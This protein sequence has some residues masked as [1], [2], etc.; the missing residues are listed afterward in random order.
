[1]VL[2][3]C[4]DA[5]DA[6]WCGWNG[7]R[8]NG[9]VGPCKNEGGGGGKKPD[10]LPGGEN[11]RPLLKGCGDNKDGGV[12]KVSLFF[13]FELFVVNDDNS[14]GVMDADKDF[15]GDVAWR[16]ELKDVE[17]SS[18]LIVVLEFDKSIG[19]EGGN[20]SDCDG[21]G[22][23]C[24]CC[25]FDCC[26]LLD[27]VDDGRID[28]SCIDGGGLDDVVL[29]PLVVGLTLRLEQ[30]SPVSSSTPFLTRVFSPDIELVSS[31]SLTLV[32]D[33]D[34]AP[35]PFSESFSVCNIS[36]VLDGG[37]SGT[38]NEF[39]FVV[40]VGLGVTVVYVPRRLPLRKILSAGSLV[41]RSL[42]DCTWT[43]ECDEV[44]DVNK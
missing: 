9:F 8:P 12:D 24:C 38:L 13:D 43:D 44:V 20:G 14:E 2:L 25:C 10:G 26:S 30:L 16:I 6:G 21:V 11:S 7:D 42:V 34:G 33:D 37:A 22:C 23:C 3:L 1:M 4:N 17:F 36:S 31:S 39:D 28:F 5:T 35:P 32:D 18:I 41:N 19:I 29:A 15:E 27:I 40:A